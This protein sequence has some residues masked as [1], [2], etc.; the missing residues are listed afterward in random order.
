MTDYERGYRDAK[1]ELTRCRNC[2]YWGRDENHPDAGMCGAI[3]QK[4]FG[5]FFCGYANRRGSDMSLTTTEQTVLQEAVDEILSGSQSTDIVRTAK[6]AFY[7]GSA[8]LSYRCG[9][10]SMSVDGWDAYCRWCGARLEL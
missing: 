5:L 3:M 4:T 8:K 2:K 1:D 10:C 9:G 6:K 7:R